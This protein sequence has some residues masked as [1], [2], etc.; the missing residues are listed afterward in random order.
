MVSSRDIR[1]MRRQIKKLDNENSTLI[2]LKKRLERQIST[3]NLFIEL[4][5]NNESDTDSEIAESPRPCP[6]LWH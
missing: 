3:Q 4:F 2:T 5:M 6:R 1:A